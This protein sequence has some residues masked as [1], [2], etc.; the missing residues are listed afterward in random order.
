MRVVSKIERSRD[1]EL[2][3]FTAGA[4]CRPFMSESAGRVCGTAFMPRFSDCAFDL[5]PDCET[6]WIS[7]GEGISS[8][9]RLFVSGA[10]KSRM[11]SLTSCGTS[12][13]MMLVRSSS[14]WSAEGVFP[15]CKAGAAAGTDGVSCKSSVS[16]DSG[17]GGSSSTS[18][19]AF[20]SGPSSSNSWVSFRME[21][22]LEADFSRTDLPSDV[23]CRM[24][25]SRVPSLVSVTSSKTCGAGAARNERGD[26]IPET[27][28]FDCVSISS[29]CGNAA[30]PPSRFQR[31]GAD[32]SKSEDVRGA[33]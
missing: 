22:S 26:L 32:V 17:T 33:V 15:G 19:D 16:F 28:L 7:G 27:G 12:S 21:R 6:G 25:S 31:L 5:V 23:S 1:W 13:R 18:R 4:F 9:V 29:G 20:S 2:G 14:R 8:K 24:V 10:S 3:T 11:S 30:V